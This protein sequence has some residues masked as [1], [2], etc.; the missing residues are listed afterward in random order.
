[1]AESGSG[2]PSLAAGIVNL[3]TS[4]NKPPLLG[5]L[6]RAFA[7]ECAFHSVTTDANLDAAPIEVNTY[8]YP[9]RAVLPPPVGPGQSDP[10]PRTGLSRPVADALSETHRRKG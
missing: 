6:N 10:L 7:S 5:R 8:K 2:L 3:A 9:V 4:D 1:M